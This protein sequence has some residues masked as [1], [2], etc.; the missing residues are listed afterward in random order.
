[1]PPAPK[2]PSSS[3]LRRI[4][5]KARHLAEEDYKNNSQRKNKSAYISRQT[6]HH[7]SKLLEEH[8]KKAEKDKAVLS[9]FNASCVETNAVLKNHV[10]KLE[11]ELHF[12]QLLGDLN[13]TRRRRN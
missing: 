8:F 13:S 6:A 4:N 5:K 12:Q 2:I 3:V 7:Y 9:S 10:Q 11:R 1:M